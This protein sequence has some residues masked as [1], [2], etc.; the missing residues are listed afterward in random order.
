M[1][2]HPPFFCTW[3]VGAEVQGP[4]IWAPGRG[5]RRRLGR[6]GVRGR[7]VAGREKGSQDGG[8]EGAWRAPVLVK[9]DWLNRA[10]W[11]F[12]RGAGFR[13]GGSPRSCQ[14]GGNVSTRAEERASAPKRIQQATS[15]VLHARGP[16]AKMRHH[17]KT[18]RA[19][20]VGTRL[21][22]TY[23]ALLYTKLA[24]QCAGAGRHGRLD[25]IVG[26]SVTTRAPTGEV[27]A[28]ECRLCCWLPSGA[29]RDSMVQS[30]ELSRPCPG[31]LVLVQR[32]QILV[33]RITGF[34][35]C[36][37]AR[38]RV[39]ALGTEHRAPT[40][41]VLEPEIFLLTTRIGGR[42]ERQGHCQLGP[43]T[44]HPVPSTLVLLSRRPGH[45]WRPWQPCW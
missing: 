27:M 45:P 35:R 15:W 5:S 16:S 2:N 34:D 13:C 14:A 41:V 12:P 24:L 9:G 22:H 21:K 20:H 23:L 17:D 28:P 19:H 7:V 42:G 36:S 29:W 26:C 33:R 10:W 38:R 3:L 4:L 32:W 1:N 44:N 43:E 25:W 39:R 11:G 18:M 8:L 30:E 37:Q 40:H 6:H 31:G